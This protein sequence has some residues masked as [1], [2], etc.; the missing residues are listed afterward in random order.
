MPVAVPGHVRTGQVLSRFGT[1]VFAVMDH[2]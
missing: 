2:F 1:G